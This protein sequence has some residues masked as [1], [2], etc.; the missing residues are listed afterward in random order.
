[1]HLV[2]GDIMYPIIERVRLHVN[3]VSGL[4]MDVFEVREGVCS[5]H[6]QQW[7][8]PLPATPR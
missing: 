2:H 1:V 3:V 6:G 4:A 7:S 8:S 5:P